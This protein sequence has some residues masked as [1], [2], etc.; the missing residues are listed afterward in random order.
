MLITQCPR[1][2]ESVC[3]P[4]ALLADVG[5]PAPHSSAKAQCPWCL[6]TL[7]PSEL[8][9]ALPPALVLVGEHA[10]LS[11]GDH[12]NDDWAVESSSV[13]SLAADRRSTQRSEG[14]FRDA[15]FVLED[16]GTHNGSVRSDVSEPDS[17]DIEHAD[18]GYEELEKEETELTLQQPVFPKPKS[19]GTAS[20][21]LPQRVIKISVPGKSGAEKAAAMRDIDPS[22][23]RRRRRKKS[24]PLKT[25]LG[26]ALGGLLA[27]PI[28]GLILHFVAGQYVPYI[29]DLLPDGGNSVARV[30]PNS[31]LPIDDSQPQPQPA[32]QTGQPPLQ[33]QS[34]GEDITALP[35]SGRLP[36]PADAA[37]EAI[38]GEA[39]DPTR[40]DVETNNRR[41]PVA[42]ENSSIALNNSP[43]ADNL[44]SDNAALDVATPSE[45]AP[46]DAVFESTRS[47]FELPDDKLPDD[48]STNDKL[49]DSELTD[50]DAVEETF[51]GSVGPD[52][53]VAESILTDTGSPGMDLPDTGEADGDLPT[54][55]TFDNVLPGGEE[56]SLS[57]IDSFS[58]DAAMPNGKLDSVEEFDV[59]DA[60]DSNS[61]DTTPLAP[62]TAAPVAPDTKMN[63]DSAELFGD[64]S[65]IAFPSPVAPEPVA[66]E[67]PVMDL[68]AEV[69]RLGSS[70]EQIKNLSAD[71]P[72]RGELIQQLYESLSHLAGDVPAGSA[73]KL[74]PLL[75]E[76][77]SN[78]SV[79]IAFAKATPGWVSRSPADRGNDGV[80]V[81]GRMSGSTED[82]TFTLLDQRKLP[83]DLPATTT[84]VPT[85]FQLGLGRISGTGEN[86]SLTLESLESIKQ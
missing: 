73:D 84:T 17:I 61:F 65:E 72:Q 75:E 47:G 49:V 59:A 76:I 21:N 77:A 38:A 55:D 39:N 34:L 80:I 50:S 63:A 14:Q 27:L 24:S 31:P 13:S 29:S 45:N 9:A 10:L 54:R 5:S 33:G 81:V 30:R 7:D 86:A 40:T 70:L 60:D 35:A 66:P 43:P 41:N 26:V 4:D 3:V 23:S 74:N 82:A 83:V 42:P 62:D 36:D 28:V 78:T 79:M 52:T 71:A 18:D 67:S 22:L 48:E 37:M 57:G 69:A 85:G 68:D 6:E 58:P 44:S 11:S 64:T 2:H 8:R 1:C 15:E 16:H 46:E 56:P 25:M 53:A 12:G 20:S 32:D 51:A 19:A